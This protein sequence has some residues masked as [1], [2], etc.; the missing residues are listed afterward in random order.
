[1]HK[2]L[3]VLRNIYTC[4]V[5]IFEI[6]HLFFFFPP[7][8]KIHRMT[9]T[10]VPIEVTRI[11]FALTSEVLKKKSDKIDKATLFEKK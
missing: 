4:Y 11:W 9:F 5:A 1:M 10:A 6:S 8:K 2:N 7:L 3:L